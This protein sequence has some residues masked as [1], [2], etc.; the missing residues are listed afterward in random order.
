MFAKVRI[1]TEAKDN[2]VKIPSTAVVTRFGEQFLFVI[3]KTDPAAPVA[4]KRTVVP[5]I[6][7]DGVMEIRQGLAPDEEI[8]VRGQTLLEEGSRINIIEQ[9]APLSAN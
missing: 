2:I 9:F 8:V 5:G 3:D 7:I 6:L 4:R 1:I